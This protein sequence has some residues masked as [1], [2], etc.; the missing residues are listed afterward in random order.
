M[1]QCTE[2]EEVTNRVLRV[3]ECD[4]TL[5]CNEKLGG[6]WVLNTTNKQVSMGWIYH[7]D[8]NDFSTPRPF[9]SWTLN[10]ETFTWVPPV[11]KP[12]GGTGSSWDEEQQK[13]VPKNLIPNTTSY[14][15]LL[16]TNENGSIQVG[17]SITTSTIPG[18]H[19]KGEPTVM[20]SSKV[21]DF[22]Q[23]LTTTYTYYSNGGIYLIKKSILNY[24]P[25][26]TFFNATDLIDVLIAKRKKVIS[27]P[28]S[29]YWLDVGKHEDFRQ[30]QID[31]N[32]LDF[33]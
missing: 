26:E 25:K 1:P 22:S 23:C 20:I 31:V 14:G 16:I 3:I 7:P 11:S 5:W 12:V 29:G 28:F 19:T 24:I 33:K 9:D 30:A 15:K 18:Y 10:T 17:D 6:N 32:K 2:L 13:W 27:Y 4:S 8:N 21:C